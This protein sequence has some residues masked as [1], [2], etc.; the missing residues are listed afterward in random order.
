MNTKYLL[1]QEM[2]RDVFNVNSPHG[3]IIVWESLYPQDAKQ[4]Y[5][6]IVTLD[7]TPSKRVLAAFETDGFLSDV[8]FTK[9]ECITQAKR[10]AELSA[11]T[12]HDKNDET[13]ASIRNKSW[14]QATKTFR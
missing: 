12:Q 10:L 2:V 6:F 8:G 7:G 13:L 1:A 14:N 3:P 9:A 5:R 4:K 11:A